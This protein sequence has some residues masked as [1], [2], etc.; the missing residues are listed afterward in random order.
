PPCPYTTRFRSG[1]EILQPGTMW[2]IRVDTDEVA[3][4][5]PV[6]ADVA[7][8]VNAAQGRAGTAPRLDAAVLAEERERASGVYSVTMIGP[9]EGPRV[10][11][12]LAD[13][14]GVI[15]NGEAAMVNRDPSFAPDIMARVSTIV[16]DE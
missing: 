10:A 15:V 7:A 8:A 9:Q 5:R 11:E 13:V 1:V 16:A 4:V 14:A 3:D 6:A 12:E 2:R